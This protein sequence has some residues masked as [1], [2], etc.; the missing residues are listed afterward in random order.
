VR[1]VGSTQVVNVDVRIVAATHMPLAE[2]IERGA[3]RRD[4]YARLAGYTFM[5]AP[6]RERR[7]D[8]GLLIAALLSAGKLGAR[9]GIR[10]QGDA[11]RALVRHDWPMNVREL[12]QCLHAACMLSDDASSPPRICGPPCPLPSVSRRPRL[13]SLPPSRLRRAATASARGW[14]SCSQSMAAT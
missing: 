13:R 2:L 4:L 7:V 9:R 6:L 12:E 8:I 14:S 1:P 3:F 11:A 5:L 10:L